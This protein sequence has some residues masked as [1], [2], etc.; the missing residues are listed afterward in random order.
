MNPNFVTIGHITKDLLPDGGFVPGGTVTFASITARNLG[1]RAG[2]ITAAPRE[3]RQLPLYHD[4]DIRG[5]E[6][7]VATIFENI[8][9]PWG[10][11]QFVRA[12]APVIR[13]DDVP[14]EWRGK[15]GGI[16]IVHLGPVDQEC[17]PGLV[18]AF[19]DAL[20]GLTPQ[21][22]MREW[23]NNGKV[24]AIEWLGARELL[25]RVSALVLSAEDLPKSPRG[26]EMLQEF[27]ELC[28]I[29]AYTQGPRG[30]TI[31]HGGQATRVPAYPAQEIDP[32]GAGDV[33]ATAY[34][35]HL[36]KTGDPI[37]AACFANAA[38]ACNIEKP[39]ATG[40]PTLSEVEARL[41][42]TPLD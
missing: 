41:R 37:E 27:I 33:F 17:D 16:E 24:Q 29:V 31:F 38:A 35:L 4:I 21:G 23:P 7:E 10:R 32:T 14:E 36:L 1:Q 8:Y 34:L 40:V 28:P 18:K 42:L 22:F 12:T 13:F 30:C 11:E 25:P 9:Q 6:T 20:I 3:L 19:P 15:A 26:Q 2:M 39:G 5:P